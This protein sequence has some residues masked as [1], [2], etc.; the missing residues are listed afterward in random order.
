MAFHDVRF[1][2]D[3]SLNSDGG[4]VRR[5][6]IISL[7]NGHEVRNSPWAGS[8]R[9]F[10]AGY[11]VKALGDIEAVLAF[12]EARH[13]RLHSFRWRDPFDWSSAPLGQAVSATDQEIGTGDGVTT[14]FQLQKTYRSGGA[15]Y[16]RMITKPVADTVR[17][18]V[19]GVLLAEAGDYTLNALSGE[20]TFMAPPAVG[21]VLTAGFEFDVPVRFDSDELSINMSALKA[22]NIP[23]IPVI[24]VLE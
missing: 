21:A 7:A 15:A 19:D 22:G 2:T 23:S 3:I 9:R 5:T 17:V 16:T 24:E 13:G 8:R 12:F 1:P 20:V 4:P 10:N 18:A 14:I 11:G 6:D